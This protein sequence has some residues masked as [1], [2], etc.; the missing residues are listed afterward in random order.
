MRAAQV[1][2]HDPLLRERSLLVSPPHSSN[3]F[4]LTALL[5]V[6]LRSA[7]H[8]RQP[9]AVQVQRIL[10]R[11]AVTR[12]EPGLPVLL[13]RVQA[14]I[15]LHRVRLSMKRHC[16]HHWAHGAALP[17]AQNQS[18]SDR[19]EVVPRQIQQTILLSRRDLC[20][21]QLKQ[22]SSRTRPL[23]LHAQLPHDSRNRHDPSI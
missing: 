1:S 8:Q 7:R 14:S 2:T 13:H 9:L 12:H 11:L 16:R 22:S 20:P 5:V 6:L 17:V 19:A 15:L 4:A 23:K 10:A 21:I 3:L 18:I